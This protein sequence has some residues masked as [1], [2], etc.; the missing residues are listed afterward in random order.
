[1]HVLTLDRV[2][3]LLDYQDFAAAFA[4]V[5]RSLATWTWFGGTR[6]VVVTVAGQDGALL[7]P[8]GETITNLAAALR[9][10]GNP[11]VPVAVLPHRPALFE[12]AGLVR[13]DEGNYDPTIVLA[14]ARTALTGAFGFEAHA[15]GQGVVQSEVITAIQGVPGV[16][17][18]KLTTFSRK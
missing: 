15:L 10:S 1:L 18:A 2:V 4:G 12:V 8:E 7:D 17:A 14:A 5:A 3:S 6:G 13:I 11:Y 9:N 16:V